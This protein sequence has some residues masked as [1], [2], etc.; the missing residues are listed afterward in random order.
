MNFSCLPK[1]SLSLCLTK[2]QGQL[3]HFPLPAICVSSSVNLIFLSWTLCCPLLFCMPLSGVYVSRLC[4]NY[5]F[6]CY[7]C[8]RLLKM[9][10]IIS[11]NRGERSQSNIPVN[12]LCHYIVTT[13]R[14]KLVIKRE[15]RFTYAKDG[16][17]FVWSKTALVLLNT[18]KYCRYLTKQDQFYLAF[19]YCIT[20]ST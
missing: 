13:M 1:Y 8:L 18:C 3:P 7:T 15:N 16:K 17:I 2:L 19:R 4:C 6:S 12:H 11:Q 10:C 14:K 5:Y 20:V 9:S